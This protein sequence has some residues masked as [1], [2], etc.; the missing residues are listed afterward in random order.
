[1]LFDNVNIT[2]LVNINVKKNKLFYHTKGV[3]QHPKEE[4]KEK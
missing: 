3:S 2:S 1:M 4:G